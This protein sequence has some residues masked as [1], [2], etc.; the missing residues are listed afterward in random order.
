MNAISTECKHKDKLSLLIAHLNIF[1]LIQLK[2]YPEALQFIEDKT[3]NFTEKTHQ[4]LKLSIE[5]LHA[6]TLKHLQK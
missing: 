6:L 3:S 2:K 4:I 1:D 5:L